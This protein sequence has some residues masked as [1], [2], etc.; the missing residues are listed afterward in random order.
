MVYYS[1][2]P[3]DVGLVGTAAAVAVAVVLFAVAAASASAAAGAD[4][5]DYN[6]LAYTDN[7]LWASGKYEVILFLF[8]SMARNIAIGMS[9]R[10]T[11]WA[12]F[13]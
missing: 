12:I 7:T 8:P 6:T 9:L 3:A 5:V 13:H 11:S 2:A 4:I 1:F 10:K